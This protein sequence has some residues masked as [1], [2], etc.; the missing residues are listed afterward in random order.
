MAYIFKSIEAT[1]FLKYVVHPFITRQPM[2]SGWAGGQ[3]GGGKKFVQTVSH[4]P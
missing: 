2:V 3:G 4:K 1:Q